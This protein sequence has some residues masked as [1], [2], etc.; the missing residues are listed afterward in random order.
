MISHDRLFKELISSFFIEF[1]ELFLPEVAE[2]ID[3]ESIVFLDKE[4]FTDINSD[5]VHE[6]DLIVKC[7][8]LGSDRYFVFHIEDQAKAQVPF[9]K[10]MFQY[11]AR[12]YEKKDMDVYPVV[13]FTFDKPLRPEPSE[14]KISCPDL[15]VLTFKYRVIQ[16]NQLDWRKF[17]NNPNP[18]AAALM[19]KMKIAPGDRPIVKLD[20]LRMTS[21]LNLSPPKSQLIS[22]IVHTYLK[23]TV[24]ENVAFTRNF[25]AL[26]PEEK[27]P[28]L[29]LTNEWIEAG[30][31][32]GMEKGIEKGIEKGATA[33]AL[34]ILIRI[35]RKRLGVPNDEVSVY[36]K[37]IFNKEILESMCEKVYEVESWSELFEEAKE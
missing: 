23:L 30:I 12:I 16:L 1:I 37:A 29:Q 6:A 25:E 34:S 7:K 4:I 19:S 28:M 15:D 17:S 33:E 32:E 31:E 13:L 24:E 3:R 27:K 26:S 8:V 35:G 10:R 21:V 2:Y 14:F 9:P 18:V 20:C 11:Y 36:L 22:G 5:E